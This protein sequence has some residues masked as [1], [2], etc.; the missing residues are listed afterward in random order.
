MQPQLMDQVVQGAM[1]PA[2]NEELGPSE[3]LMWNGR[4]D[5]RDDL[6]RNLADKETADAA[7]V[8]AAFERWGVAGLGRVIGDWSAVIHDRRNQAIVLASDYAGV[9][10]LYYRRRNGEISW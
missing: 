7:L 10:P 4:L 3:I 2:A 6:Q 8:L 9:R 5:N 1:L